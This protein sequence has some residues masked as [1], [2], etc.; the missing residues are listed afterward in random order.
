MALMALAVTTLMGTSAALATEV[1][2][3]GTVGCVPSTTTL[4]SASHPGMGNIARGTSKSVDP[5][6][7]VQQG[8]ENA[9]CDPKIGGTVTAAII[10]AGSGEPTGSASAAW[11]EDRVRV[12]IGVVSALTAGSGTMRVNAIVPDTAQFGV[13]GA[14]VALT[15]VDGR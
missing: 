14:T 15:L 11:G 6:F 13:F 1:S 4:T 5:T 10:G 7:K 3:G 12:S 8:I 2:V 9:A